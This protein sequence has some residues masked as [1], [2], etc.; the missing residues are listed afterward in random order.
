[1]LFRREETAE[2]GADDDDVMPM[3]SLRQRSGE[4]W[5]EG[6]L[7]G[8]QG[9]TSLVDRFGKPFGFNFQ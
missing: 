5:T 2:P 1:Q 9:A 6:F 8:V 4:S 7:V 3:Y